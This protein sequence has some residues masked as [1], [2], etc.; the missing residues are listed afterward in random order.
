MA[1]MGGGLL[2]LRLLLAAVFAVAGVAK[3]RDLS[4][5][6]QGVKDFGVPV[7]L[8]APVGVALPI[9]E[10][11]VAVALIPRVTAWW[12]AIG[13]LILL[14]TF[15]VAVA[16]N[17]ARGNKPDCRC[18][19]QVHSTPVG[20]PT[21][22]RNGA[23]ATAAIVLVWQG[24][25]DPGPDLLSWLGRLEQAELAAL[26]GGIV[27][28]A[29]LALGASLL[30]SLLRQNGRLLLRIEALEERFG[31]GELQ[32]GAEPTPEI[33]LPVGSAAPGFSLPGLYGETL[34]LDFLRAA[35]K[36]TL[37]FFMH[38]GCSP[39]EALVPEVAGWQR[40][41]ASRL[42]TAIV[43]SGDA[44]ENRN[45]FSAQA[46][47]QV[48]LEENFE[49]SNA[50][51]ASGTPVAVLIDADGAIGSPVAA[52]AEQ[53]RALVARV[54]G[55]LSPE[56][57]PMAVPAPENGSGNGAPAQ[58]TAPAVVVGSPAPSIELQDLKG[59]TTDLGKLKGSPTL[60]VFWNPG[61][62]FCQQML[63]E[64]K[65]WEQSKPKTAPRLIVVSTGSAESNEALGFRS[66]VL[67]DQSFTAGSAFG[68][69]GTPMAVLLDADGKVA[70]DLAA[71][72]PAVMSLA[73]GD[74]QPATT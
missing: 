15:I 2:L 42:T 27:L 22:V 35:G 16:V 48:M 69:N 43:S 40:D 64:L 68:A 17:L 51:Q 20:W 12:G 58:A 55:Q 36:P 26:L 56:L 7:S 62:G 47:T 25:D 60:V 31:A 52:G 1:P 63:D 9:A 23:L 30:L 67:L 21:L 34:T 28:L 3:L 41:H 46:L 57:L 59:R 50:Y 73:R 54:V 49:V 38:P 61:C 45:K 8:A 5:T 71:G 11:I 10:L 44:D 74:A 14:A 70:S 32:P 72:G 65:Q 18:F 19:G 33:G 39:C 66:R 13:A 53:V 6:R 29:L 24:R 4:G 37:L